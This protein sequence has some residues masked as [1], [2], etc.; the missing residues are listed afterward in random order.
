MSVFIS[1]QTRAEL[2]IRPPTLPTGEHP[3]LLSLLSVTGSH[4]VTPH[5][6]TPHHTVTLPPC[7]HLNFTTPSRLAWTLLAWIM[8]FLKTN[9]LA[10]SVLTIDYFTLQTF[11]TSWNLL[12]KVTTKTENILGKFIELF[13]VMLFST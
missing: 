13:T 5:H 2:E 9:Q 1:Q 10:V 3:V 12:D 11:Y 4:W 6:T 8:S 7:L